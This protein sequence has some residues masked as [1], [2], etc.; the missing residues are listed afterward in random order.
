[1]KGTPLGCS[2]GRRAARAGIGTAVAAL[3]L[4][5]GAGQATAAK[6]EVTTKAPDG[7]GSFAAAIKKANHKSGGDQIG[8]AKNLRGKIDLPEE[9]VTLDGKLV[10]GGNGYGSPDD[11]DFRRVVLSGHRG[12]SSILVDDDGNVAL[13]GLYFDGV[14]LKTSRSTLSVR[15]SF[16][17]GE[18]T[19][20]ETGI[21]SGSGG[22]RVLRT[23][24]Q[25]FDRGIALS[26]VSARID[27]ST[28][29]DNIGGG[30]IYV[31]NS[32]KADVSNSTISGNVVNSGI[33]NGGGLAVGGYRAS[34]RV[35]NSTI[36][37]NQAISATSAGG[38]L[39]GDVE[40]INS[41]I[42]GNRAVTGAGISGGPAGDADVG[43]SIIYGNNGFDGNPV[44][45]AQPF[46]SN[47]GNLIGTPGECLLDAGDLRN[48][49]PLLGPLD[50]NGGATQTEA[51][52]SGSPA[53]G[54]AVKSTA[55][56]FDQRGEARDSHPDA[57]AY[58]R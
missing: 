37:G 43:N 17:D 56:K 40:V 42:A 22:L 15:D 28:I 4:A 33:V 35:T 51:I 1:M 31:G 23:T 25:G 39:F 46:T 13:R 24:I 30:G 14:A 44:D 47:G 50:D 53:I 27:Q 45:C 41:T 10:I 2:Q 21:N 52:G 9:E 29:A 7:R 34:A 20:D 54:L 38:G 57:G 55:T 5:A 11:K 58:E 6:I 26:D 3:T 48:V 19:V 18:R 32:A 16:L 36:V 12:G 8:F 49:D